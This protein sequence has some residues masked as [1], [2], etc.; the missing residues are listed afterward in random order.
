MKKILYLIAAL[1]VGCI[2]FSCAKLEDPFDSEGFEPIIE[3]GIYDNLLPDSTYSYYEIRRFLLYDTTSY[4]VITSFGAN[5]Y[6]D[7]IQ[8]IYKGICDTMSQVAYCEN[9]M[10]IKDNH[11][12]FWTNLS[13]IP[14]FLGTID[15][16]NEA[17]LLAHFMGFF[18]RFD[19]KENGIK[20]TG[21]SYVIH[22]FRY[23][24]TCSPVQLDRFSLKIYRSGEVWILG[25]ETESK[26][27]GA[28]M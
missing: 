21:D 10:S 14:T 17:L 9:I 26:V 25:R 24:S 16:K 15:T 18:F 12:K 23:V 22:A 1:A 6:P 8:P 4:S 3:A 27:D 13:D 20:E 28:C 11:V 5:T 7:S 2:I 19:D